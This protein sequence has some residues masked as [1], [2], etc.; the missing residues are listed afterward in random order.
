MKLIKWIPLTL[1]KE[2]SS[3][4]SNKLKWHYYEYVNISKII[5]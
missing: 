3:L 5:V 2:K 4:C 1:K